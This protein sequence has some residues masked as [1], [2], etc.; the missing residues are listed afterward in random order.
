VKAFETAPMMVTGG[1]D[2]KTKAVPLRSTCRSR[3]R[4]RTLRLPATV[5]DPTAKNRLLARADRHRAVTIKII[6]G[7]RGFRG[8]KSDRR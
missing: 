6:H 8:L 2:A 4:D 1:L 3:L 5:I 7:L